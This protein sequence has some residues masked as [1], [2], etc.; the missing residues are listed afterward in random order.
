MVRT[1]KAQTPSTK[2]FVDIDRV[3][4]DL[5][6]SPPQ[7]NDRWQCTTGPTH[8]EFVGM[9][10]AVKVSFHDLLLIGSKYG[11]S[12]SSSGVSHEA[13]RNTVPHSRNVPRESPSVSRCV[14][15]RLPRLGFISPSKGCHQDQVLPRAT[16]AS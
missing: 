8:V 12:S 5:Q 9:I 14:Q 3:L 7:E 10:V 1:L 15:L 6:L 4:Q 13:L 2:G 16:S 11:N